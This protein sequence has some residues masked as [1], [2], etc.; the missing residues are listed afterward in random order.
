MSQPRYP[1]N[2]TD[3]EWAALEL[4]RSRVAPGQEY[5]NKDAFGSVY[6]RNLTCAGRGR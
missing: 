6:K 4:L 1:S 3:E 5:Q 2:P